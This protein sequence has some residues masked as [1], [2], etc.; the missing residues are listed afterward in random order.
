M[1]FSGGWTR[2]RARVDNRPLQPFDGPALRAG[3]ESGW[4]SAARWRG[5]VR[6]IVDALQRSTP[7]STF[8]ADSTL[9]ARFRWKRL[10]AGAGSC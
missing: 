10:L 8:S 4:Q 6:A 1:R 9:K 7:R 5:S 3:T 2:E